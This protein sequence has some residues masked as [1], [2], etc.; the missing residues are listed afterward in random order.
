MRRGR[1][2]I[3]AFHFTHCLSKVSGLY[4]RGKQTTVGKMFLD[5][6]K[7]II[8]PRSLKEFVKAAFPNLGCSRGTLV[9][10]LLNDDI[11][12]SKNLEILQTLVSLLCYQQLFVISYE[13]WQLHEQ[14]TVCNVLEEGT[15]IL[16]SPA[17]CLV[18]LAAQP[19]S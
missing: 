1:Q 15:P 13:L 3:H 6:G 14:D 2:K 4:S 11:K 12:K 9:A 16:L 7:T 5:E 8:C 18:K 10:F 17:A 19:A